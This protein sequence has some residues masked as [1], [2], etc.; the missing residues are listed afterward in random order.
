[1][2]NDDTHETNPPLAAPKLASEEKD[3]TPYSIFTRR[4]KWFIVALTAFAG[5][6]SPLTANIYFPAIP[7][8]A[9]VFHKST[10][11][12]NLTVTMYMVL[13]GISP[14]VWGT[15]SDYWGRRPALSGCLLVLSLSCV[16]LALVPTSDYWL[17]MLLRCLQAAG[18][19]STIAIGAGVIGDISTPAERGG[20]FG[21]YS[22][23]P[24][25][26]PAIGPVIGGVL[27][28][29]LGWRAIFWFL[30]IS[31]SVCIITLILLFP[32]TLRSI[33]GNGSVK[34]SAIHRPIIPVIG[35]SQ[36][37]AQ[38][39]SKSPRQASS[40]N[41]LKIL[42]HVDILILLAI[43]AITC[44]VMY[45]VNASIS[46]LFLKTYPQ[47]DETRI[48]LTFLALGGGMILG[49][50]IIG[51][52][53]DWEFQTIKNQ[54]HPGPTDARL[55]SLPFFMTLSA[56]C[57]AG[58]GW[59]LEKRVSIAGPLILQIAIGFVAIAVMNSTQTLIIDLLPKQS[60]SATA[61]NNLVR[62]TF[63]AVI[64]S[65]IDLIINAIGIGWT[66]VLLGGLSLVAVPLFYLEIKIGPNYRRKRQLENSKD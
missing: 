32:E 56:L 4:E 44:G 27:A 55:R 60:S 35:R 49:S 30:C 38:A 6:F 25:I 34:P 59:C 17:L 37:T 1:M 62:C 28:D 64:V 26:G 33:V 9:A 23:G 47:L 65:V 31:S 50:C 16:G 58:Y 53:L 12:I 10:E 5:L 11:L 40:R 2:P 52:F 20:F 42:C 8:L 7:T 45:G 15:L 19:A 13:Q 3:Q 48:G 24:M 46:T 51:K 22:L 63:S 21:I 57:C 18:S 14:M 29:R 54:L 36:V 61:C 66:Y 41:P 43:N 39:S